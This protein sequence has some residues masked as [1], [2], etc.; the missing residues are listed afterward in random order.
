MTQ[1]PT[2]QAAQ[3]LRSVLDDPHRWSAASQCLFAALLTSGFVAAGGIASAWF[4]AHPEY[5]PLTNPEILSLHAQI[6]PVALIGWLPILVGALVL[7][8]TRPESPMLVVLTAAYWGLTTSAFT[9]L[10]GD[11][12]HTL[13]IALLAGGVVGSIFFSRRIVIVGIAALLTGALGLLIA[14]RSDA[15]PEVFAPGV[16]HVHPYLLLGK[17]AY[18]TTMQLLSLLIAMVTLGAMAYVIAHWRRREVQLERLSTTDELTGIANRRHFLRN[19]EREIARAERYGLP[20]TLVMIDLDLFKEIN[21]GFG[22][23]AGDEV[24]CRFSQRLAR[25]IRAEDMVGRYGGEEFA[26][27]LPQ[28]DLEGA[29]VMAERCRENIAANPVDLGWTR[30]PITASFGLACRGA[31]QK[32]SAEDLLRRADQ[33]LYRAKANGRNRVEVALEPTDR[34]SPAGRVGSAGARP[35]A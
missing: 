16:F 19:L 28:T 5:A 3:Y 30:V 34:E 32:L 1:T 25:K 17:D 29:R 9:Y 13:A 33:A 22:H 14:M 20:L 12:I 11:F 35:I 18:L 26:I 24:L 2:T 4:V 21:D 8:R 23:L 6:A 15:L 31:D 27:V 7:R 10:S